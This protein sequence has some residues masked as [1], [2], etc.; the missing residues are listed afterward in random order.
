MASH[1]SAQTTT[2]VATKVFMD[3]VEQ[4]ER[5]VKAVAADPLYVTVLELVMEFRR[6]RAALRVTVSKLTF[7]FR[8]C[9][10]AV[11]GLPLGIVRYGHVFCDICSHSCI[12]T[13][14]QTGEYHD[15]V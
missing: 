2:A 15:I 12:L 13:F 10:A 5:T 9:E 11:R 6:L 1:L 7:Q 3:T 4:R 8:R 14:T